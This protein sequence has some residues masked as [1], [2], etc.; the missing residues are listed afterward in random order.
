MCTWAE[1]PSHVQPANLLSSLWR[2]AALQ[3]RIIYRTL[4][5]SS[6]SQPYISLETCHP[7]PPSLWVTPES[8]TFPRLQGDGADPSIAWRLLWPLPGLPSSPFLLYNL[9]STHNQSGCQEN[10]MSAWAGG[11]GWGPF[12]TFPGGSQSLGAMS[13]DTDPQQRAGTKLFLT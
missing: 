7:S 2:C 8:D 12:M 10:P 6:P 13:A 1:E 9:V 4:K 5:S 11:V 3:G